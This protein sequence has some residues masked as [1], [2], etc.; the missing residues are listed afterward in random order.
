VHHRV[1]ACFL[2]FGA[3]SS[4]RRGEHRSARWAEVSGDAEISVVA[5]FSTFGG[6][7]RTAGEKR[8]G[9]GRRALFLHYIALL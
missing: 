1:V 2:R 7:E 3:V 8:T 5:C 4:G 6:A 9:S